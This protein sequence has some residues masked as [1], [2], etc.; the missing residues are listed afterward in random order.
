MFVWIA[1]SSTADLSQ[2]KI[3]V[4]SFTEIT[5]AKG[6]VSI[7]YMLQVTPARGQG[8]SYTIWKRMREFHALHQTIVGLA[9]NAGVP[10]PFFGPAQ[11]GKRKVAKGRSEHEINR[12][13]LDDYIIY[14]LDEDCFWGE[15][16]SFC[17]IVQRADLPSSFSFELKR[18]NRRVQEKVAI[19]R[20]AEENNPTN[21]RRA[22]IQ[23][24]KKEAVVDNDL[25]GVA[26]P[27]RAVFVT[28]W[29]LWAAQERSEESHFVTFQMTVHT[30]RGAYQLDKSLADVVDLRKALKKRFPA[31]NIPKLTVTS[32]P[33]GL[34]E[35]SNNPN[36]PN[37]AS[38]HDSRL[39][40][41]IFLQGVVN[42]TQLHSSEVFIF[43]SSAAA[44]AQPEAEG[45]EQ[46]I[47]S[48]ESKVNEVPR[49]SN[50]SAMS[51]FPM[52][53]MDALAEDSAS[54]P[55]NDSTPENESNKESTP[56]VEA[57]S[58]QPSDEPSVQP[59]AVSVSPEA[60]SSKDTPTEVGE[61]KEPVEE[62]WDHVEST[63]L[64]SSTSSTQKTND[65]A[66]P[67]HPNNLNTGARRLETHVVNL[68]D[69]H[70][71][72]NHRFSVQIPGW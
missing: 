21:D 16:A 53:E 54:V 40:I 68:R 1:S 41:E 57:N 67:N 31:L 17:G 27:F 47:T 61:K 13:L 28:G 22:T 49:D 11:S 70:V 2:T 14:L 9:N 66:N 58:A 6:K 43:L 5:Q 33:S 39:L 18:P 46:N 38:L 29:S 64:S 25:A 30:D 23:S 35:S 19:K 42:T 8:D 72:S 26:W 51:G 56:K 59:S 4:A 69:Q 10:V 20:T 36:N 34:N 63:G 44:P 62:D 7:K 3:T 45:E 60:L 71:D 32:L 12:K 37:N 15:L 52:K 50:L 48:A 55:Q 65:E 24:R